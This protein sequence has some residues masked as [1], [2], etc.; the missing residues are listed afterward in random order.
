M[1]ETTLCTNCFACTYY[2]K[3]CHMN[4]PIEYITT[5]FCKKRDIIIKKP[6]EEKKCFIPDA[7]RIMCADSDFD[8]EWK[9]AVEAITFYE[10]KY[11][12]SL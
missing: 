1:D 7:M 9:S 4:T 5:H 3:K 11:N 8:R 6:Y 2:E 12:I 10:K